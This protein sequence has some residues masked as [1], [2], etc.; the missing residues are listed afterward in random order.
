MYFSTAMSRLTTLSLRFYRRP[1][2]EVAR[3]LL[4]RLIVRRAD[5]ARLVARIVETEAYLGEGDRASHA[6]HGRV[7]KRNA[8]LFEPGGIA[9]VFLIYGMYDCFNA[10]AGEA[11]E[12]TAV[13]IRAAEPLEGESEMAGRR[14]LERT[15]RPGDLAGG[16]GKLCQA[17]DITRRHD[18]LSLK[19]A[20][21]RVT[22]G[23]PVAAS[24]IAAGPRVGVDYAGEA[25]SW[26]LRF[27]MRGNPHVSKPRL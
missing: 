22:E 3:D 1:C 7:T 23:E 2:E 21:L 13:L 14:A 11:G 6:W 8:T 25:A 26:Q 20:E 10:V 15:P 27:A 5:G 4:G 17:L 18:G 19:S 9:Y 24:E 12:G 16:P